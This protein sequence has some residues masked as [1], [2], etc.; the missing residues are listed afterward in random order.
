LAR[1]NLTPGKP[2]HRSRRAFPRRAIRGA[3]ADDPNQ[4][5][6]VQF[7]GAACTPPGTQL[8]S[9]TGSLDVE[10][11]RMVS[12]FRFR[13]QPSSRGVTATQSANDDRP[14][15]ARGRDELGA[16]PRLLAPRDRP[17]ADRRPAGGKDLSTRP[18]C[19]RSYRRAPR[20][21]SLL[22]SCRCRSAGSRRKA[23]RSHRGS[24]R[25][26]P[27]ARAVRSCSRRSAPGIPAAFSVDPAARPCP[28]GRVCRHGRQRCTVSR[29]KLPG[30]E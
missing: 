7:Q 17:S 23:D 25:A 24:K 29:P 30:S 14:R 28:E 27:V 22:Q 18:A 2:P 9:L 11:L 12:P 19:A 3:L 6:S 5:W 4:C 8:P 13:H 1:M 15:P 26:W 20:R 10:R 16:I 21:H